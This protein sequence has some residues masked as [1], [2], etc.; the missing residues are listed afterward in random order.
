MFPSAGVI[1]R[2]IDFLSWE[3]CLPHTLGL[4]GR[5]HSEFWEV[6]TGA[7]LVTN[8]FFFFFLT[9][10]VNKSNVVTASTSIQLLDERKSPVVAGKWCISIN[11][12]KMSM[13]S[14]HHSSATSMYQ[15]VGFER[16]KKKKK[17]KKTIYSSAWHHLLQ[18]KVL[19][20]GWIWHESRTISQDFYP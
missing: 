18:P 6:R 9:G 10:T 14:I 16:L 20:A 13:M 4:T 1:T 7:E 8:L 17:K 19:T 5:I 11:E 15:K 12:Y 3:D 2:C